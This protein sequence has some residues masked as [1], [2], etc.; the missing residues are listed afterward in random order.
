MKPLR[1]RKKLTPAQRRNRISAIGSIASTLSLPIAVMA[2]LNEKSQG[3]DMHNDHKEISKNKRV[4]LVE[5]EHE[6]GYVEKNLTTLDRLE[7][8]WGDEY[9]DYVGEYGDQE[10]NLTKQIRKNGIAWFETKYRNMTVNQITNPDEVRAMVEGKYDDPQTVCRSMDSD[11]HFVW[12]PDLT[13]KEIR[14]KLEKLGVPRE[15]YRSD[16]AK[17]EDVKVSRS[18]DPEYKWAVSMNGRTQSLCSSK[19][20]AKSVK[21]S[22]MGRLKG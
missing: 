11:P 18:G 10:K 6:D 3:D 5:T 1:D 17:P 8:D 21:R 14:P 12:V 9:R 19:S 7:K 16:N 20:E 15:Y 22:L 13:P 4:V 2:L